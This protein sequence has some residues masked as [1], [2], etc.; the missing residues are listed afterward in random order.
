MLGPESSY[1]LKSQNTGLCPPGWKME[2]VSL[3]E[4]DQP[5]RKGRPKDINIRGFAMKY[6]SQITLDAHR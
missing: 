6:L 2:G 3:W 4:S 5:E 1:P